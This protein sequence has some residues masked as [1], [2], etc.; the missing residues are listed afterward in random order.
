M[1]KSKHSRH[2]VKKILKRL[3]WT[4][5][6]MLSVFIF[7]YLAFKIFSLPVTNQDYFLLDHPRYETNE[8]Y[9]LTADDRFNGSRKRREQWTEVLSWEPRAFLY[10]N[11]LS[12]EE[13]EYLIDLAE[14]HLR[15]SSVVGANGKNTPSRDRTSSGMFLS[16]G[17]DE[18]VT[19]IEQRIADFT[20]IPVE[21]GEGLQVLRYQIGE[22][23]KPHMDYFFDKYNT[24][25]GTDQR[26]AT[27]LMYL[28]DVEEGGE[29]LFPQ[30]G[31]NATTAQWL[32][33]E[34][35]L[36]KCGKDHGLQ[37]KPKMGNALLFWSVTPEYKRTAGQDKKDP[38]CRSLVT[39]I[40]FGLL[41][42]SYM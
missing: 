33:D 15:K 8:D 42:A 41:I 38:K 1:V 30:S 13:C 34:E 7:M 35:P 16:R 6:L 12:K 29:T 3:V 14:P 27:L 25:N 36:S 39:S 10:H 23:Y 18:I 4:M 11:F 22:K 5:L 31:K 32:D 21:N 19:A 9:K 17:H 24:K 26:V 20:L 28:S 37:V 40:T 2:D